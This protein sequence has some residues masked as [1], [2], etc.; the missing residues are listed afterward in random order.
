MVIEQAP[1]EDELGDVLEKALGHA[2][3]TPDS[4]AATLGIRFETIALS[5]IHI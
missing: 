3:L 1:M 2:L 5:L 4:L